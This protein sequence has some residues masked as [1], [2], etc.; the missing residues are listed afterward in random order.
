MRLLN[1]DFQFCD[2]D[3]SPPPYAILSHTWSERNEEEVSY[4]DLE[5][6]TTKSLLK[7]QLCRDWTMAANL[8]YFWIDT[9]CIDKRNDAE[10]GYAIRSMWRWYCE[11]SVCFVY[12]SDLSKKRKPN[13]EDWRD[14]LKDCRWFT[15]GWTLQELVASK[16]LELYAR[17]GY[18]GSR[19]ALLP[20]L[21]TITGINLRSSLPD[22]ATRL[23]WVDKRVTKRPEDKAYCMLGICDVSLDPRY[24]EG[25]S[26]AWQRLL[27]AI[28]HRHGT[29]ALQPRGAAT[30]PDHRV[31]VLEA[32]KFDSLETR[33]RTVKVA[34]A[35]TCKWILNHPACAKWLSW[36]TS[37]SGSRANLERASQS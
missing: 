36:S 34:L 3:D 20:A 10:I 4:Q 9:C 15:R 22:H 29:I 11:A 24:G 13:T 37:S 35:K 2:F 12:L 5:D 23:S 30:N 8:E 19:E 7:L 16:K 25:G 1:S 6:G 31:E 18:L 21:K 27:D 14:N 33:R 28:S 32:L 26:S 17:D